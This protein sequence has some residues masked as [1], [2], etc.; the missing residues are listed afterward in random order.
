MDNAH[1]VFLSADAYAVA[2][3]SQNKDKYGYKVFRALLD[4]KR[5][6]IPLNP[7][8]QEIDGQTAYA[9]L[10]SLPV[11]PQSLSIVTPPPITRKVVEEAI[12]L[13]V[14]NIWMQPGAED[15][16]A[17]ENARNAGL[18]VIDDGSCVLVAL[19]YLRNRQ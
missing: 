16:V 17:S 5:S 15:A 3:A 1:D 19:S 10:S 14:K 18:N 2:G 9:S 8:A 12:R 7:N 13:G 4:S 6:V 11:V